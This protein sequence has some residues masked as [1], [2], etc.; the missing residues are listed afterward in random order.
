MRDRYNLQCS[1]CWVQFKTKKS[2]QQHVKSRC[3]IVPCPNGT[4]PD[5]IV[6]SREE[7]Q[8]LFNI[9]TMSGDHPCYYDLLKNCDLTCTAVPRLSPLFFPNNRSPPILSQIGCVENSYTHLQQAAR[10][11]PVRLRKSIIV[12]LFSSVFK[13][14]DSLLPTPQQLKRKGLKMEDYEDHVIVYREQVSVVIVIVAVVVVVVVIVVI[15]VFVDC[16][17]LRFDV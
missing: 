6:R 7:A 11:G 4:K 17:R 13:V 5:L 15:L 9:C 3:S 1:D 2:L 10:E 14:S 8:Q 16:R 12:Q